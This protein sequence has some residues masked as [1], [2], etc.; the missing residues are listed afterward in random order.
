MGE[1]ISI[2][3]VSDLDILSQFD[4]QCPAIPTDIEQSICNTA[5]NAVQ[6]Q[7]S[8]RRFVSF[9]A[10]SI[11]LVVISIFS[12]VMVKYVSNHLASGLSSS[13]VSFSFAGDSPHWRESQASWTA[14]IQK[15]EN[16]P[17]VVQLRA[18]KELFRQQYP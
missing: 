8:S 11:S 17:V 15:L 14:Y 12:L 7:E 10:A 5:G 18:E 3:R 16:D 1:V 2:S 9:R 6:R 13:Q 4:S